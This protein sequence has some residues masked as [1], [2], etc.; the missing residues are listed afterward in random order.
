MVTV[1]AALVEPLIAASIVFVAV[2][3]IFSRRLHLWRPVV[4]FAFGLLHGL[5]FASVLGEFGLPQDQVIPALLGFNVGV[6]LGQLTVIALAYGALGYW[7][8][9]HPKY[10]GRVAIPA[11]VTIALIGSYWFYERVFG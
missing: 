8:G 1:N 9:K 3:N 10:R 5:G 2:E 7:F 6:E 4:V 11:S